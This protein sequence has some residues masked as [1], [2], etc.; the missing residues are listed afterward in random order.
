LNGSIVGG[1]GPTM[2]RGL[3]KILLAV[4]ALVALVIVLFF[5]S[6]WADQRRFRAAANPCERAC[7]QDSGGLDSCRA[8]C[9]S[10]PLTYGPNTQLPGP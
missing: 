2:W 9:V 1:L 5:W 7:V 3:K 8:E 4:G 6:F 10:H